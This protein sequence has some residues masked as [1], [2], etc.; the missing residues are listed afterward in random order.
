MGSHVVRSRFFSSPKKEMRDDFGWLDARVAPVRYDVRGVTD[1]DILHG[2]QAPVWLQYWAGSRPFFAFWGCLLGR[3]WTVD[4]AL[5][6]RWEAVGTGTIPVAT[7]TAKRA[8]GS[9][10]A[11]E[12]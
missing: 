10:Q 9:E 5:D 8:A 6:R 1:G 2:N 7:S 12:S 11:L 4:S 3:D